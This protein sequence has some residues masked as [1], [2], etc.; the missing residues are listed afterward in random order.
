MFGNILGKLGEMKEKMAEVKEK[1]N[2]VT[3]TG[4]AGDGKVRV[5]ANGNRKLTEINIYES[6]VKEGAKVNLERL[7]LEASNNALDQAEEI[8]ESEMKK[9]A[10]GLLPNIPGLF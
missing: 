6:L 2:H 4:E 10:K 5:T 8:N 1:L 3:V 7:I 9:A